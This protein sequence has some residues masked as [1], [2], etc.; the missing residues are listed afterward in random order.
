MSRSKS[1]AKRAQEKAA[2]AIRT[3]PDPSLP[4]APEAPS[5]PPNWEPPREQ[6]PSAIAADEPT[7]SR[8]F[9]LVG[10]MLMMLG[11]VAVLLTLFNKISTLV[12]PD[13][14]RACMVVGV[15]L[16][17]FH[18]VRDP[19]VQYRRMYALLGGAFLLASLIISLMPVRDPLTQQAVTAALMMTW[20]VPLAAVGLLFLTAY[21]RHEDS[22]AW[23]DR[24]IAVFGVFGVVLTGVG[25]IGGNVYD[26]FLVP[27]GVV[28]AL[29]GC[30]FLWAFIAARGADTDAGVFAGK[31]LGAIGAI[32]FLVALGRSALP[33]LFYHWHWISTRPMPYLVPSGLSLMGLGLLYVVF[34]VGLCSERPLVVMTRR[35]LVAYFYSPIA[36]LVL[37]GFALFNWF[38]YF[39]FVIFRLR[40]IGSLPEPIIAEY[41]THFLPLICMVLLGIP[42]L[43][44]RLLSE[45][46]ST[47]TY[48]M[49]M[50]APTT[51]TT[52]V[53]SKFLGA[54]FF[55][56]LLWLPMA[57]YL[58]ALRVGSGQEFEYRPLFGFGIS[59]AAIG[60]GFLSMG[61][62]F[63][64]L[65]R[66]QVV[67]AV[68]TSVV[69]LVMT[70]VGLAKYLLLAARVPEDSA[71]IR[72]I[73]HISYIDVWVTSLREGVFAPRYLVFHL[74]VTVFWLFA[75]VKVLETRKWS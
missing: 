62:F 45:E 46:R 66:S 1:K 70:G 64:S 75:T 29:L 68:L 25:L 42:V 26:K 32:T 63:S 23:R 53:L 3:A 4:P 35:E 58:V 74:S 67:A 24:T 14:G 21:L 71:W 8:I 10:L 13:L 7:W 43:T 11:S 48:E 51:E 5:L 16:M 44:M 30:M 27:Q 41:L 6:A 31:A 65:T 39:Y 18:A 52:I 40:L 49:L 54:F 22:P 33:P 55:Y 73:S 37:G 50:T 34:A 2:A 56:L 38:W 19:D 9:G 17:V 57:L 28:L 61:L 59:V 20:G 47:G 69:T 12:G 72:A 60:A 15:A 36:Y